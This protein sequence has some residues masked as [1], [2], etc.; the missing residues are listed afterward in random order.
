MKALIDGDILVYRV[1]FGANE[2]SEGIA[3]SRMDESVNLI[4]EAVHATSRTIFLTS[5]DKSNFRN[6]IYPEYKANRKSPKPIHY[7]FL[8]DYL[9][10]AHA[11]E[12]V[13]NEEADDAMGYTQSE[14]NTVICTIDKDLDQ[15][16]G[17]HYNF[18]KGL[19]YKVTPQEGLYKFYTQL[20]MGDAIDNIPG[21]PGIGPKKAAK[22]ISLDMREDQ[23]YNTC[24]MA[25]TAFYG[26]I[27]EAKMLCFGQLLK[28]R[29]KQGEL[30]QLKGPDLN[31][32]QDLSVP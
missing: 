6:S 15:I 1:G 13:Y 12:I 26:E 11:A 16:P 5:G 23:M 25:Y 19:L 21:I 7:D 17:L 27:A 18:V 4:L 29:T 8:R 22:I 32:A 10:N 14:E 28:I 30:W 9:V 31:T 3:A 20:L 24:L 2:E